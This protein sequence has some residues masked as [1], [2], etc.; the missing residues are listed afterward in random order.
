[1]EVPGAGE[2][3]D[4]LG[5]LEPDVHGSLVEADPE[6]VEGGLGDGGEGAGLRSS[7]VGL[8][9]SRMSER[10]STARSASLETVA[11]CSRGSPPLSRTCWAC[12][13][14]RTTVASGVRT[15][16][17]TLDIIWPIVERRYSQATRS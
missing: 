8:A 17:T 6:R 16:C 7:G 14:V 4:V 9:K 2:N 1:M 15:S 11:S 5:Q 10:I 13:T 3:D 12:S